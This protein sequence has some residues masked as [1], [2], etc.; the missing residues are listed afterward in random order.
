MPKAIYIK[1]GKKPKDVKPKDGKYFK[2]KELT[3]FVGGMVEIVP[4]PSGR[5]LVCN[6]E[7]QLIELEKNDEATKM[8]KEEYPIDKYPHNNNE[9]I[10]GNVLITDDKFLGE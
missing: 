9:L 4:M 5:Y 2:Y 10:V 8:W 7:G 1:V 3:A 6:E